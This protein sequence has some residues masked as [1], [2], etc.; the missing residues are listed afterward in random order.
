MNT[1]SIVVIGEDNNA[2][3]PLLSPIRNFGNK[4]ETGAE[5]CPAIGSGIVTGNALPLVAV[6]EVFAEVSSIQLSSRS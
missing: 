2:V 5:M 6:P 1:L 4:R 3:F